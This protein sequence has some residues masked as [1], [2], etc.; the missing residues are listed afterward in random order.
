MVDK[1]V[2]ALERSQGAEWS[3]DVT[4]LY[5]MLLLKLF[6]SFVLLFFS[7]ACLWLENTKCILS[8]LWSD[9]VID[10]I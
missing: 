5:T 3:L 4:M 10:Q 1:G 2:G 9:H 8:N 7:K 6:F